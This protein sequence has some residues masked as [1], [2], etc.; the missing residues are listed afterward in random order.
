MAVKNSKAKFF[1]EN[2]GSEV[3]EDAK[4]CKKCGKFFIS[5]R[6]PQCGMTGSNK[7]FEKGCPGC[8]Y[9]VPNH[10]SKNV[11]YKPVPSRKT[12][13]APFSISSYVDSSYKQRQDS[14]LP[15]WIY[16]FV[17]IVFLIFC[18]AFYSCIK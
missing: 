12:G 16:I 2:C 1:C 9:A 11:K 14:P 3:P 17:S 18:F 4:V 13:S 7:D 8:G 15:I 6:C 5:V 10:K